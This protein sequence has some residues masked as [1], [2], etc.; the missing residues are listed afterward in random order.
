[1]FGFSFTKDYPIIKSLVLLNYPTNEFTSDYVG[2]IFTSKQ[3]TDVTE[4]K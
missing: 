1:M 3:L 4:Y 2:I